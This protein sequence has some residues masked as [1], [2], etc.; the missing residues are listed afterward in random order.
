MSRLIFRTKQVAAITFVP[1]DEPFL[2]EASP[3]PIVE[4]DF[5][6]GEFGGA[7]VFDEEGLPEELLL[8]DEVPLEEITSPFEHGWLQEDPVEL[9]ADEPIIDEVPD[10][11]SPA[12]LFDYVEEI[13]NHLEELLLD[14]MPSEEGTSPFEHGWVQEDTAEREEELVFE[15]QL[16]EEIVVPEVPVP[17]PP[18]PPTPPFQGGPAPMTGG[19]GGG[20]IQVWNIGTPS[21]RYVNIAKRPAPRYPYDFWERIEE[22]EPEQ[23]A[24]PE[25]DDPIASGPI[26]GIFDLLRGKKESLIQRGARLFSSKKKKR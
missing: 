24:A 1:S 10:D 23:A 13:E 2:E 6:P 19:S 12:V 16:D 15:P 17:P 20:V 22:P 26:G 18:V 9:E 7:P 11:V 14:E 4:D 5:V 8:D 3:D 25:E 21:K